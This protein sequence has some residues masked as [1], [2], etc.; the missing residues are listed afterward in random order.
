MA[1]Q[2]FISYSKQD[3]EFAFK[4][5]SD[6]ENAGY[7]VWIDREIG[8]GQQWRRTIEK[9][10]QDST[11]MV[12]IISKNSVQS[13]WVQH[14]SSIA[15]GL[16]KPLIPV[17]LE[18]VSAPYRFVWMDEIQFIDFYSTEYEIAFQQ[19]LKALA[20]PNPIQDLLDQQVIA[21]R[22]TEDLIGDAML[23]VIEG[24][25]NT[26]VIT[27]EAEELIQRSAKALRFRRDLLRSGIGIVIILVFVA[28]ISIISMIQAGN[29]RDHLVGTR[30]ARETEIAQLDTQQAIA[31]AQ[32]TIAA[33][34]ATSQVATSESLA[35]EVTK[36][37]QAQST[38]KALVDHAQSQLEK[39]EAELQGLLDSGGLVLTD[40]GPIDLFRQGNT[41]WVANREADTIQGID[42]KSKR[43]EVT[44]QV[45][46]QPVSLYFD[47][48]FLWMANQGDNTI[49][50][51]NEQTNE[52]ES[53][54]VGEG[55]R[56]II[57]DGEFLWVA[58]EFEDS[59]MKINP[60]SGEVILRLDIGSNPVSLAYI[61]GNIWVANFESNNIQR[62][63]SRLGLITGTYSVRKGPTDL[64][65]DGEYLWIANRVDDSVQQ[66]N[67]RSG[68]IIRNIQVAD[69]PSALAYDGA[70]LWVANRGNDSIQ[71]ID[72]RAGKV[73]AT[74]QVGNFPRSIAW[75][76]E[77]IW[78]G[79][80]YDGTIQWIERQVG[81]VVASV[82][83]SDGPHDL[84][85]AGGSLWVA[86]RGEKTVQ[87]IDLR[88]SDVISEIQLEGLPTSFV[89]A[90]NGLWVTDYS[91]D[92]LV[93]IADILGLTVTL[94][95]PQVESDQI[96]VNVGNGPQDALWDGSNIWV[97]NFLDDSIMQVDPNTLEVL[98]T[99][100]GVGDGPYR[101]VIDETGLWVALRNEHRLIQLDLQTGDELMS[102]SLDVGTPFD[103]AWDGEMLWCALDNLNE[104]RRFNPQTGEMIGD[105]IS[106]DTK[107]VDIIVVEDYL[108][109]ANQRGGTLQQIYRETGKI[110]ESIPIGDDPVSLAF[111]NG[112]IWV[113]TEAANAV[114][115]IDGDIL[116]LLAISNE[117]TE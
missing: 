61:D 30:D 37:A 107:P 108:W 117:G 102:I 97:A 6:I 44:Y 35:N 28:L 47:G 109:V 49:S 24:A 76:G 114:Q 103:I 5:A 89:H 87:Q 56:A 46:D 27:D 99:Y 75:D 92:R 13:R 41:L 93:K 94:V 4:L 116:A 104:L 31:G 78:V 15:F 83:V 63:D 45:G 80:Y 20:P 115:L 110:T 14:E 22:Q 68:G 39:T 95:D 9:N 1:R 16:N 3:A 79:N 7:H 84:V 105:P 54:Q 43:K 36:V 90:G 18:P 2:I 69:A 66:F 40:A 19:L 64:L 74:Y 59:L 17:L 106:V 101:L 51:V 88:T 50:K 77:Y 100:N 96:E 58:N 112:D 33:N 91:N 72:P 26:L 57:H 11:E 23:D 10:I 65:W 42:I 21:Y 62:V 111:S 98:N 8:G 48:E 29:Q 113:A 73:M 67:P 25:R 71:M 32:A 60:K 86:S 82:D 38:A 52:I 85:I 12:V 34:E 55:P 53:F 81:A 70:S